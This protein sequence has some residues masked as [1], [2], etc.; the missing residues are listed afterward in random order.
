M[1]ETVDQETSSWGERN[2]KTGVFI[3]KEYNLCD[4]QNGPKAEFFLWFHNFNSLEWLM[5][6]KLHPIAFGFLDP[7]IFSHQPAGWHQQDHRQ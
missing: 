1:E 5:A 3:F 7:W 4:K 6:S 2:F